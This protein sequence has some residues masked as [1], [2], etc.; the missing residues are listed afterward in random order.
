MMALG[1]SRKRPSPVD[2]AEVQEGQK[3]PAA[4]RDPGWEAALPDTA[5]RGLLGANPRIWGCWLL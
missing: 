4:L 5:K 1:C 2:P 3:L